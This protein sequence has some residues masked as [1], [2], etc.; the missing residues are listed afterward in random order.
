MNRHTEPPATVRHIVGDL[1]SHLELHGGNP[2]PVE[3]ELARCLGRLLNI[4]DLFSQGIPRDAS[5]HGKIDSVTIYFDPE[6]TIAMARFAKGH[7]IP[8]H[9]H[10][11]WEIVG[12][13]RGELEYTSYRPGD[14]TSSA[15]E[16]E[17]A[18]CVVVNAGDISPCARSG[19]TH[20]V[21]ALSD[22]EVL[23]MRGFVGG[24][25][26]KSRGTEPR[27]L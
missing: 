21:R 19:E 5:H 26:G 3:T 12:V 2:V 17:V 1:V 15:S 16:L 25:S 24:R 14:G 20:T 27:R 18:E 4:E 8:T 23:A 13:C 7:V 11:A 22:V 10:E 6:L 9:A